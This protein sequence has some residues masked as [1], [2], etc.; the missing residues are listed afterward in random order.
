ME[1]SRRV[2][3][4]DIGTNTLKFSV[5]EIAP[6]G[7][8][9]IV[10]ARAET[11]RL[12]AGIRESGV[13]EPE[14]VFRA[15]V[16]LHEYEHTARALGAE[17][18]LGV[19]TAALR[20][21]SNGN[22]LLGQIA[23]TTGWQVNVISGDEEARLT[24]AGLSRFLPNQGHVLLADIGGG[25]TEFLNVR[26]GALLASRSVDI[27]SGSMADQCFTTDPPG[28]EAVLAAADIATEIL[29]ESL[30][31]SAVQGCH[32]VLSGGNGLFLESLSGW[33]EIAVPFSPSEFTALLSALATIESERSATY[34]QIV[35]ERARMIP[36]GAAIVIAIV[37]LVSPVSMTALPSGIRGGLIAEWLASHR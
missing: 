36:A 7:S 37:R 23:R 2:A 31:I 20:M 8:E 3:V 1:M 29:H 30:A 14:R 33:E 16:A 11:I 5:T 35:P 4:V 6:D 13:I 12:G 21:A 26:D 17:A 25:S 28:L 22:D 18:F 15:I 10:D 32:L 9:S 19:A 24:Y 34:L 27:G